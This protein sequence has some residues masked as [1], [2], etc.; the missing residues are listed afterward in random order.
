M[1]IILTHAV[2]RSGAITRSS[3]E[4]AEPRISYDTFVKELDAGDS[5]TTSLIDILVQVRSFVDSFAKEL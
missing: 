4:K 1:K 2:N 3:L 5:F